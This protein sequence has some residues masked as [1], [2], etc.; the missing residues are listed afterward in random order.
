MNT[1][2]DDL[3]IWQRIHLQAHILAE[4]TIRV[5]L[6][7]RCHKLVECPELNDLCDACIEK[8]KELKG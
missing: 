1:Q 6:C 3:N 4:A 8:A 2:K 5:K 7:K